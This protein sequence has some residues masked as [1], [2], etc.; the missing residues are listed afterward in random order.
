MR[1]VPKRDADCCFIDEAA[2]VMPYRLFPA[3]CLGF[4]II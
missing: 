2:I 1:L 4:L 3:R